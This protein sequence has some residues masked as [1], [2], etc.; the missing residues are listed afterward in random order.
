MGDPEVLYNFGVLTKRYELVSRTASQLAPGIAGL[1]CGF[2]MVLAGAPLP[3]PFAPV[4]LGF[5]FALGRV[6][7]GRHRGARV[8]TVVGP[9]ARYCILR[10]AGKTHWVMP[11]MWLSVAV[12]PTV[13]APTRPCTSSVGSSERIAS[14]GIRHN[15]PRAGPGRVNGQGPDAQNTPELKACGGLRAVAPRVGAAALD[16]D[17][18]QRRR[19]RPPLRAGRT[20]QPS[21]RGHLGVGRRPV[22][23]LGPRRAGGADP[24]VG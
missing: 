14:S 2:L 3:L 20:S 9:L 8:R 24:L 12:D 19:G 7:F 17:A 15:C 6:P 11:A 5:W 22:R 13:T 4:V 21:H 18:L 1:L 16:G 23:L 10:L